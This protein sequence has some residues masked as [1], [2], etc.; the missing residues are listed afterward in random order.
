MSQ[1]NNG[2]TL[3]FDLSIK[4][5]NLK[6]KSLN[7]LMQNNSKGILYCLLSRLDVDKLYKPS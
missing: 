3:S 4:E 2:L 5:S 1:A 6:R 7:K